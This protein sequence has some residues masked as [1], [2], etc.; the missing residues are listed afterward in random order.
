MNERGFN[1][2]RETAIP[3]DIL[4]VHDPGTCESDRALTSTKNVNRQVTTIF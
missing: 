4:L 1:E 3:K 2:F